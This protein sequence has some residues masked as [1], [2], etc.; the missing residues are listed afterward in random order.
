MPFRFRANKNIQREL[1]R[2]AREQ[3]QR[4]QRE[5]DE[6][7]EGRH[8]AVHDVRKRCKKIRG[9]IRLV[10]PAFDG[11]ACV[12]KHFRDMARLLSVSRDATTLIECFDA[13]VERF[14]TSEGSDI[15]RVKPLRV[16]LIERRASTTND[17]Q[18]DQ[19]IDEVRVR[20]QE[21]LDAIEN[22]RLD[23][24]GFDAVGGGLTHTYGRGR[25]AIKLALKKPT[26][27]HF[28]EW[29]K[30]V[31]YHRCHFS[32]LRDCWRGPFEVWCNEAK[33]L[34]DTLGDE[35]DLTVFSDT[36]SKDGPWGIGAERV[37]AVQQLIE[38]RRDE[39]RAQAYSLGKRL[40]AEKPQH[41]E[42]RI[43]NIWRAWRS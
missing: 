13:L 26:M 16:E 43:R 5:L 8:E 41:F 2:I 7:A 37:A 4:A 32:L 25:E 29:R 30:E 20:L 17:E 35:H 40:Y 22:W 23:A 18:L 36:L 1:R 39:L 10:R 28:H 14:A 27:E 42:R 3:V 34:G 6:Q 11:Y 12:N 15:E 21:S 38:C 33:Q 19:R 9:L 24:S 31:K